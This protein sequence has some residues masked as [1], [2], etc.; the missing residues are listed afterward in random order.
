[1]TMTHYLNLY[2]DGTVGTVKN[3]RTGANISARPHP[4]EQAQV[5]PRVALIK[6]TERKL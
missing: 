1:M 6:V 2:A 5:N 3:C 4:L